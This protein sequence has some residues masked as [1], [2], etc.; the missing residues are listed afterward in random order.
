MKQ[1]SRIESVSESC[2]RSRTR[3]RH[4]QIA[5]AGTEADGLKKISCKL[6]VASRGLTTSIS[7]GPI[8]RT[9]TNIGAHELSRKAESSSKHCTVHS[10]Q[11]VLC[12]RQTTAN[13][14]PQT[15]LRFCTHSNTGPKHGGFF[16]QLSV[17]NMRSNPFEN[18]FAK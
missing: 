9:S 1:F 12:L 18:E 6:L 2:G 5:R 7:C 4:Y 3:A 16:Q 13:P 15:S 14:N 8:S 17:W 11:L 10:A